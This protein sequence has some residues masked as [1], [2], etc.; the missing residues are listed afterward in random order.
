M[1]RSKELGG[2][3][4]PS[5]TD[6]AKQSVYN[7]R[8]RELYAQRKQAHNISFLNY[9]TAKPWLNEDDDA[10]KTFVEEA[11]AFAR[12]VNPNINTTQWD[13]DEMIY[14]EPVTDE[15][16][17]L[18][19]Y[20]GDG[21]ENINQYLRAGQPKTDV[22][23]TFK[24]KFDEYRSAAENANLVKNIDSALLKAIPSEKPRVL[25]RSIRV[26]RG[27][28]SSQASQWLR[29]NFS[30]G[31]VV[32]NPGY[33]SVSL[34]AGLANSIFGESSTQQTAITME[35]L[36]KKGAPLGAGMSKTA[37]SETELLLPRDV[38][39]KVVSLEEDVDYT[40]MFRNKEKTTKRTVIRLID[41]ND[42]GEN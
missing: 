37:Y 35:I 29:E 22:E 2:R 18:I 11:D 28:P 39:L 32:S 33:M 30:V 24:V 16:D 12:K 8:R 10:Y 15:Q 5:H 38:K 26:P 42:E 9:N 4:C 1:C 25:Y 31:S 13:D 20:S 23:Q 3:R 19:Q 41:E 27:V 34:N 6:P 40:V 14:M 7:A 21:Y 17:A 36:S